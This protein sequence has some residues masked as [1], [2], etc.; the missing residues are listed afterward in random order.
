MAHYVRQQSAPLNR[1]PER[2]MVRVADA[3]DFAQIATFV[4]KF[5]SSTRIAERTQRGDVCVVVYCDGDVAHVRWAALYPLA[6]SEL[7]STLLRLDS[8]EAYMYDAYTLPAFRHRGFAARARNCL[9]QYL[10]HRGVTTVYR[11]MRMNNPLTRYARIKQNR[12]GRQR[13]LGVVRVSTLLGSTR[14]TFYS[15]TAIHRLIL[16]RLFNLSSAM[17]NVTPLAS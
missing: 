7:N 6:L 13:T 8:N 14:C 4:D 3:D 12:E 5:R 11:M 2:V 1:N 10:A 9:I 15:T 17:V 16:T